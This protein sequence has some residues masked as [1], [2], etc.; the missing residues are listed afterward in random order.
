[1]WAAR[2]KASGAVRSRVIP[3]VQAADSFVIFRFC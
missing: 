3:S 1:M 2:K